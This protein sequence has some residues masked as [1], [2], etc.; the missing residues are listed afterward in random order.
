MKLGGIQPPDGSV[1][2][3]S[4]RFHR[5]QPGLLGKNALSR[6][7]LGYR[8]H[9][10]LRKCT[11]RMKLSNV[12]P[13]I[14]LSAKTRQCRCPDVVQ[15]PSSCNGRN[16]LTI[17]RPPGCRIG[18]P[19]VAHSTLRFPS[20]VVPHLRALCELRVIATQPL[21]S[22][23]F[24]LPPLL[25]QPSRP[26]PWLSAANLYS[27]P[28]AAAHSARSIN[29]AP[30]RETSVHI[31]LFARRVLATPTARAKERA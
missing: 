8:T 20:V 13:T 16:C 15:F 11:C 6:P 27:P 19:R 12:F 31:P 28:I 18:L 5:N 7:V 17:D 2:A 22:S 10:Q 3:A 29:P 23:A 21:V 24:V 26:A 4:R 14:T 9:S 1:P 25:A 30:E